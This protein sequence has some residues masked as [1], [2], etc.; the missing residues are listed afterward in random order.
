MCMGIIPWGIIL[1]NFGHKF[2]I[3]G[4]S[5]QVI[6]LICLIILIHKNKYLKI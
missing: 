5:V 1:D 2:A 6:G 4:V 3:L